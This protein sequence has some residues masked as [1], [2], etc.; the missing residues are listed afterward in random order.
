[1]PRVKDYD[2]H[3]RTR[4]GVYKAVENRSDPSTY[5]VIPLC[6]VAACSHPL[7]RRD[8]FIVCSADPWH[9]TQEVIQK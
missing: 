1:M 2:H 4:K 7:V 8:G 3:R 6:P 5:P 9:F